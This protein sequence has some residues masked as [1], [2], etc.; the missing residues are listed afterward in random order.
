MSSFAGF[1][2]VVI[3]QN[4]LKLL[5]SVKK[6]NER[7]GYSMPFSELQLHA[8]VLLYLFVYKQLQIGGVL[9]NFYAYNIY[10]RNLE[11]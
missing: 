4:E 7:G 5:G 9:S 8:R 10:A 1:V 11:L 6:L 3:F 2:Q